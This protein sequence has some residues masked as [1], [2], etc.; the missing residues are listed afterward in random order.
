MLC[1]ID[2]YD[3]FTYNIVHYINELD[4]NVK[5]IL[6]DQLS[7]AEVLALQPSHIILS[8]GPGTPQ[9]SGI[10]I[11]LL[12]E[13]AQKNISILGICLGHEIIGEVFGA[14]V[15]HADKVMHGKRSI[16]YHNNTDLFSHINNPFYCGR[17]HSLIVDKESL[18][19]CLEISSWTQ[20]EDG[21][22]DE[23]MGLRHKTLP[24]VG[25]QFHPES[26][27]TSFGHQMLANF[28]GMRR[29]LSLQPLRNAQQQLL[30]EI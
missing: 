3:S 10:S 11:P 7:V 28:L 21:S 13:A 12:I 17:Y 15:R 27:L 24:I 30:E 23:I 4:V 8:P 25:V 2:N 6:N 16:I 5:V 1:L 22:V 19:D 26:I 29:N 20:A 14:L 18:P 9:E